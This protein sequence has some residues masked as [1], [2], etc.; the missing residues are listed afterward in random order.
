MVVLLLLS[1]SLVLSLVLLLLRLYIE[2]MFWHLLLVCRAC[3]L[4][5]ASVGPAELVDDD[6]RA[7]AEESFTFEILIIT[8]STIAHILDVSHRHHLLRAQ[9]RIN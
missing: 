6:V 1:I 8:V 3:A 7:T 4:L 9:L 5:L 2:I